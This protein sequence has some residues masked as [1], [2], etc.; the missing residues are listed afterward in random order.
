MSKRVKKILW[1]VGGI[2][3]ILLLIAGNILTFGL[4]MKKR[5]V[6]AE[7]EAEVTEVKNK[8]VPN[9]NILGSSLKIATDILSK[10][11]SKTK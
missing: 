3:A 6:E 1:W 8:N 4:F 5:D 10:V 2:L 7:V 11:E 9:M